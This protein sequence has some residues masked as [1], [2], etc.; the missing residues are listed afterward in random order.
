MYFRGYGA[1]RIMVEK[2]FGRLGRKWKALKLILKR[3]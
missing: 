2:P 3:V 1:H